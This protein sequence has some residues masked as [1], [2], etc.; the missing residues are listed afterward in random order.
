MHDDVDTLL[1]RLIG[2]DP[3]APADV[4][5]RAG[6]D[7]RPDLLVAAALLSDPHDELLRRA[8][9]LATS[10]RDRQLVAVAAA[11]LAGDADRL[12][13]LVRDHLADHPDSLLA[14]W[15]AATPVPD[16]SNHA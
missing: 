4:L 1:R 12:D 10:P 5:A 15:I 2:G 8:E 11:H 7:E 3:S 16:R 14:A 6:T 9:L 13:V